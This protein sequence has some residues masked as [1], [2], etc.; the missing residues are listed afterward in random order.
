MKEAIIFIAIAFGITLG[1]F[2]FNYYSSDLKSVTVQAGTF[3]GQSAYS[4]KIPKGNQSQ[5][6]WTFVDGNASIPNIETTNART[7]TEHIVIDYTRRDWTVICSDD[8]GNHYTGV[9]PQ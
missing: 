7:D 9:F 3:D 6:V 5:C 1:Y 4:L 2:S 8:F